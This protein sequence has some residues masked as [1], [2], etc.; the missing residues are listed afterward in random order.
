MI[1]HGAR[2]VFFLTFIVTL[3]CRGIP[4]ETESLT[5]EGSPDW[6]DASKLKDAH[7]HKFT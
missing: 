5:Y 6:I 1:S 2:S 7:S 4:R 3:P